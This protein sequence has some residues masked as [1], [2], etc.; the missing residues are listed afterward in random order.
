M[1]LIQFSSA[2]GLLFAREFCKRAA[3]LERVNESE[4]RR[5]KTHDAAH[6]K[7]FACGLKASNSTSRNITHSEDTS[8]RCLGLCILNIEYLIDYLK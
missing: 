5:K 4:M 3:G 8:S 2:A 7:C 1:Q 6:S